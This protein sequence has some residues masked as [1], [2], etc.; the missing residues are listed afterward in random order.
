MEKEPSYNPERR[1]AISRI[2]GF[3][4][5]EE[6]EL[7]EQTKEAFADQKPYPFEREKTERELRII[8]GVL[9]KLPEFLDEYGVKP[10]AL[11]PAHIHVADESALAGGR[12]RE[13]GIPDEAGGLYVEETQGVVAF[14]EEDDLAFAERVAHEAIHANSFSSFARAG[15]EFSL[16]RIGL[17]VVGGDGRRYF[18]D[19]NEGLTEELAKRFDRKHSG[20]IPGLEKAVKVREEF[21]G[22]VRA[23]NPEANTDEIRSVIAKQRQD[24]TW[25][26][27]VEEYVYPKE[28]KELRELVN[29]IYERNTGR[30]GTSDD[31]F[32]LFVQAAFTG[33]ITELGRLVESTFGNGSFRK[34]GERTA[35]NPR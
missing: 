15:E 24:G 23:K 5:L 11:T 30:F 27:T 4:E 32:Q 28:R 10:L 2:V 13:F 34:L 33:R 20:E 22:M 31:V 21:I 18:H 14:S 7:L 9:S 12:K 17:T 25:T 26:T 1:S 16:R 3:P 6:K 29:E 8:N 35:K 19:L